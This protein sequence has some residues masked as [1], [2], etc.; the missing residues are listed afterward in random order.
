MQVSACGI[1]KTDQLVAIILSLITFLQA[2]FT[3]LHI[4]Q[5]GSNFHAQGKAYGTKVQMAM[6]F[7]PQDQKEQANFSYIFQC[8]LYCL[9]FRS[10]LLDRLEFS[11]KG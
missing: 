11:S 4:L 8:N 1:S 9:R 6:A 5:A 10:A 7:D 3:I 2:F